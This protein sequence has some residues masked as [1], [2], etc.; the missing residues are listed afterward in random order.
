MSETFPLPK[1]EK[2][3]LS[4]FYDKHWKSFLQFI[5]KRFPLSTGILRE[6]YDDSFYR[7]AEQFSDG[8]K[9]VDTPLKILL[10]RE[11]VEQLL[12]SKYA[13]KAVTEN[14]DFQKEWQQ[15]E[16][17]I[18]IYRN[19]KVWLE[20]KE[21][22]PE[23]TGSERYDCIRKLAERIDRMWT[24]SEPAEL[25]KRQM[26]IERYLAE[27]LSQRERFELESDL[28]KDEAFQLQ[29][30]ATTLFVDT[31]N[32]LMEDMEIVAIF[33]ECQTESI[34]WISK[35]KR[36]RRNFLWQAALVALILFL[37]NL[38]MKAFY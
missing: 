5:R 33:R 24:E 38:L 20:E 29:Y 37:L 17:Y 9:C 2:E 11:A 28:N 36:A 6:I 8:T 19:V 25:L 34:R 21:K 30:E 1:Q 26:R 10:F 16:D 23:I 35:E 15:Q 7:L 22:Q 14:T 4:F 3:I 13:K 12:Q 18:E 27:E 31:R 32:N